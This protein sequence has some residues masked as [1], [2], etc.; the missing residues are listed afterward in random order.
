VNGTQIFSATGAQSAT[1]TSNDVF[2][3]NWTW[4]AVPGAEGY[5]VLWTLNGSGPAG[6]ADVVA[7]NYS[8]DYV[9]WTG[10]NTTVTPTTA[11]LTPSILWNGTPAGATTIPTQWGILEALAF[12]IAD[13]TDTGPYDI[14]IDNIQ[15]G[16]T[17]FQTF[18][19][20]PANM[21]DYGFRVPGFSGSTS[22]N[23]LASPNVGIVSNLVADTGTKSFKLGFQW[24]SL[25]STKWL[26]FTTS[27]VKNPLVN[28]DNPIKIRLLMLPV[29]AL[30]PA[31]PPAPTLA[32]NYT[33]G[34]VVLNWT[35]GHRLQTSVDVLGTYTNV[36]QGKTTSN[37]TNIWNGD[38]LS[39]WTNNYPEP[40]RFFRLVD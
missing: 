14:Y 8:D 7:N 22:G 25:A 3:V 9:S 30:P 19:T 26:R 18:E 32:Q 6:S 20:A 16:T 27:G 2:V 37:W 23:I 4:A 36:L 5:R 11:Q 1:V 21:T 34:K 12:S 24:Q 40:T 17:V 35:D 31:R 38:Y 15:N 28:L 33:A 39:P 10:P 13:T 29:G